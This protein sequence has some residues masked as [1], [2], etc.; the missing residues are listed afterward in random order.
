MNCTCLNGIETKVREHVAKSIKGDIRAVEC[1]NTAFVLGETMR[2]SLFVPFYVKADAPG[3]R[4]RMGKAVP[5]HVSYCPFCGT[6]V[7][8]ANT[9]ENNV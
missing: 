8:P 6:S 4:T 2:L 5:V 1:G 3:Y 9:G 7:K